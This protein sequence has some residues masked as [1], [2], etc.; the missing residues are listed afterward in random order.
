MAPPQSPSIAQELPY[1]VLL[2][3]FRWVAYLSSERIA[4][5][6]MEWP[7]TAA[8]PTFRSLSLVCRHWRDAGQSFVFRSACFTTAPQCRL[9]LR[10]ARDRPDL[11][12]QVRAASVGRLDPYPVPDEG[13]KEDG[14]WEE[15]STLMLDC[16]EAC[17]QVHHV[18]VAPLHYPTAFRVFE[19][20]RTQ[21]LPLQSLILRL[22]DAHRNIPPQACID[23]YLSVFD[24]FDRLPSFTH[25]EINFRPPYLPTAED[26][27]LPVLPVSSVTSF[28]STVNSVEAFLQALRMMPLLKILNVYSEWAFDPQEATAVFGALKH[29]E[30]LRVESNVPSTV[31]TATGRGGNPAGGDNV[32]LDPLLPSYPNLRK[33]SVTE[34]D[35]LPHQFANPPPSLELL[36]FIHFGARPDGRFF[37]FELLLEESPPSARFCAVEFV[38]VADEEAFNRNV[39]PEDVRRVC[40]RYADKGVKFRVEH[41]IMELPE[42]KIVEI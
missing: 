38:F 26:L 7:H 5:E 19:V 21:P 6:L 8:D 17:R 31:A 35:A 2:E 1:D 39:S 34:Q 9:F 22:F 29:L 41:E 20:I 18:H 42:K 11:A 37:D 30:E 32:W 16:L 40:Q 13:S 3:I 14:E 24:L 12:D 4:E 27:A 15:L 10:T 25:F 23:F 36:E 28:H 33:L